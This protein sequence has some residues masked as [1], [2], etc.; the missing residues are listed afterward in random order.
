MS[1]EKTMKFYSEKLDM[2]F[3]SVEELQKAESTKSKKRKTVAEDSKEN[4]SDVTPTK[5]QLASEVEA[6]DEALKEA[7]SNYDSA[8]TKVQDLSKKYL[9]EVNEILEP[10]KKAVKEAE[11]KRYD[12]I[13]KFNDTYGA[14]QVTYTGAKAADEMVKAICNIN[15]Q[16]NKLFRD[17]FWF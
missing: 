9:T 1:K 11:Q 16:A 15:N 8:K 12:A 13:R 3:D 4:S 7:Y 14:Y 17:M 6:A 10:A 5:K 2:M